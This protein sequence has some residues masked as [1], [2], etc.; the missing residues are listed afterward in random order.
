[1]GPGHGTPGR[2]RRAAAGGHDLAAASGVPRGGHGA[3]AER[4]RPR[5]PL[6]SLRG[7]VGALAALSGGTGP[8]LPLVPGRQPARPGRAT[9]AHLERHRRDRPRA[10]WTPHAQLPALPHDVVPR[11]RGHRR[12]HG[13]RSRRPSRVSG[14]PAAPP[15]GLARGLL[16]RLRRRISG[17]SVHKPPRP[18]LR[19]L[20]TSSVARESAPGGPR[21]STSAGRP[22][23]VSETGFVRLLRA[24]RRGRAEIGGQSRVGL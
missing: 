24:R 8:A 11:G 13:G 6:L 16:A 9:R 15:A 21:D 2:L 23:L 22:A 20:P 17:T 4:A 19:I 18:L 12:V 14:V 1:M 5:S 10:A 3:G 7:G